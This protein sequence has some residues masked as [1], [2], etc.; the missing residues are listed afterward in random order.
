[1]EET[2]HAVRAPGRKAGRKERVRENRMLAKAIPE[3]WRMKNGALV[4]TGFGRAAD[5]AYEKEVSCPKRA[6]AHGHWKY[7]V[8]ADGRIVTRGELMA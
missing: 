6:R 4:R 5:K 3:D 7:V 2:R 1:M 8:A